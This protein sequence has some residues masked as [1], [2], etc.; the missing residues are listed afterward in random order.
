MENKDNLFKQVSDSENR[1]RKTSKR[2]TNYQIKIL[3]FLISVGICG[4]FFSFH[5]NKEVYKTKLYNLVPGYIWTDQSL[6]APFSFPVF[7]SSEVYESEVEQA[8]STA[9]QVFI[10]DSVSSSHIRNVLDSI[11]YTIRSSGETMPSQETSKKKSG[12]TTLDAKSFQLISEMRIN[13]ISQS[14]LSFLENVYSGG[15]I[16]IAIEGIHASEIAVRTPH[17]TVE[18]YFSKTDLTD[19]SSFT[20]RATQYFRDNLDELDAEIAINIAKKQMQPN[21]IYSAELTARSQNIA[22]ASVAK[23]IGIVRE[24]DLIVAK[25][26][27]ISP[28]TVNKLQSLELARMDTRES[29]YS[30]L[31]IVGSFLHALL[32]FLII[33]IYLAIIRKKIFKSNTQFAL[34]SA[35]IVFSAFLSWLSLQLQSNL[36]VEYLVIIPALSALAAI[37]FDSRTAFYITV[38][39]SLMFMGI[40]GNDY[41]AGLTILFAGTLAAY[42]VRDVQNRTQIFRTTFI[43][44]IGLLLP[45]IVFGLERSAEFSQIALKLVAI[46]INS[47]LSPIM[48]FGLLMIIERLTNTSTI[49]R[50]TEFDNLKHPLLVKLNEIAPGTYQHTM[51]VA[52]LAE[53]CAEAI[54]ANETLVK[55]GAYFHDVGKITKPEYF[56]ENQINGIGNK[57]DLLTPKKS[58]S[59]IRAHVTEGVKLAQQ[60]HLPKAIADFI[61]AHHGTTLIKYFYGKALEEAINKADIDEA[62][63]RYSGPKPQ[64]PEAAILMI[65][66]SAEAMSRVAAGNKDKLELMLNNLIKDRITDGQFSECDISLKQISQIKDVCVR[67]LSAAAHSRVEYKDIKK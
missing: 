57:H 50:I 9:L 3:I 55:V 30:A 64:I 47:A 20:N 45:L 6:Y 34:I 17:S 66:D 27:S 16:N 10:G 19:S 58:A 63:Y 7:K 42:T 67:N 25:G 41:D 36:P 13:K 29:D 62:D 51:S 48:M 46:T 40:R 53:K 14:I 61:P 5:L 37:L 15:F 59:I 11:E 49:L 56:V 28:N 43:I 32:I 4:F 35:I 21:L 12:K 22:E 31:S 2:S 33:V 54:G 38:T 24:K 39:M 1:K 23:T 18:R 60:Y 44:F 26:E 65:C 52:I 8:K